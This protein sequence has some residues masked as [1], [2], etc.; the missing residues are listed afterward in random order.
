MLLSSLPDEFDHL[1]T[2]LLHGKENVSL[3]IVCSALYSHE[4]KKTDKMKG[5]AVTD[6]ALV[7]RDRQQSRSKERRGRS[8]LKRKA[9]KDECAFCYEKGH[10][11]K[12]CPKLKKKGKAPQDANVAE[13]KNDAESDCSLTVSPTISHP[14]EWIL[15]SGCTYHMCPI[16]EWFFDFKELNGGVVYM[17]NDS[18]YKTAMIGSIKLRNHDGSTRILKDMR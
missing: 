13:C 8:K 12:D 11:K 7:A 1:E 17:G 18:P 14:S 2:T 9:A 5:K 6:E 16:R 15:D 10:W 3:D 4:L